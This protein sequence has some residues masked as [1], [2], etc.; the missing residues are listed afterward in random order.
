MNIQ[1]FHAVLESLQIEFV[2]AAVWALAYSLVFSAVA[3]AWAFAYRAFHGK[4]K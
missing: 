2:R 3:V 1:A 4:N